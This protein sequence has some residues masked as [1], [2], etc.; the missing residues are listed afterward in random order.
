MAR[1]FEE[2]RA[3]M[4]PEV[5]QRAEEKTRKMLDEISGTGPAWELSDGNR[6]AFGRFV[7]DIVEGKVFGADWKMS[8]EYAEAVLEVDHRLKGLERVLMDPSM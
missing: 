5:R 7:A 4:A 8:D 2:L 1:S 3:K 6:E